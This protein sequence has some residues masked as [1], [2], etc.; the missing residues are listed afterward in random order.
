MR[1]RGRGEVHAHSCGTLLDALE[2]RLNQTFKPDCKGNGSVPRRYWQD[3][4]ACAP[5]VTEMNDTVGYSFWWEVDG[6]ED[7][8]LVP[9]FVF[10]MTTGEGRNE[11][12]PTSL[13]QDAAMALRDK[14]SSSI[15]LR[16]A[17]PPKPVA[18][19]PPPTPLGTCAWAGERCPES[20]WWRCSA[21]GND[22]GVLGGQRQYIKKGERIP[23]PLPLPPQTLWEKL[24]GMQ[25]SYESKTQTS[26]K[27][28]DKRNRKRV[29]SSLPLAQ[30]APAAAAG[31]TTAAPAPASWS[32]RVWRS[33][34]WPPPESRE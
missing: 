9:H 5:R 12:V 7:K 29:P 1:A 32:N 14:I 3:V 23:Q 26:W 8:V 27:L 2:I 34:V 30:A 15:R 28:V 19:D 17:E 13:A 20:G 24:R 21:G 4:M 16:P 33:G 31:I 10:K 11:P 6:T 25:P 18:A 22:V